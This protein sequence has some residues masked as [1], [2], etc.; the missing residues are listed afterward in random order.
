MKKNADLILETVLQ[1]SAHMTAE[2]IHAALRDSGHRMALA[3]VYNNLAQL[4]SEGRIRKVCVEGH[5]DRYDKM[6]RHDHLVCRRC[7]KL[8]DICFQD[9][10]KL[11]TIYRSVIS[12]PHAEGRR[13]QQARPTHERRR[14]PLRYVCQVCGY[15]YDEAQNP[16]WESLPNDWKCPLCGAS[17]ADF[18]PE[19]AQQSA[20]AA[21]LSSLP[22]ELRPLSAMELSVVCSNL[23]KGC[24]KQYL[25]EQAAAFARLAD[26]LKG[27][28]E[29]VHSAAFDSLLEKVNRDLSEGYPAASAAAQEN[30]DRGAL[31]SLVWSEKVTRMLS[32]LLNRYKTEGDAMLENTG[33][34]VCAICGF[35]YIGDTPPERCPVCKVP[36]RK[37]EKIGG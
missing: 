13:T 22:D 24:E 29:P 14:I 23:A 3:T 33:V 20:P 8:T 11:P 21:S 26:W 6:I 9:L 2:E 12:V 15:V 37:F 34:W 1:S 35:V 5:P 19:G 4:H 18:L 25:L 28:A 7:G 32:S 10:T 16:P 31:R 17:K 30:R 36:G 27:Q